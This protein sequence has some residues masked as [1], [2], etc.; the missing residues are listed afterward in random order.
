MKK[1]IKK[2][3]RESEFD[4]VDNV[5]LPYGDLFSEDDNIDLEYDEMYITM[6]LKDFIKKVNG[7]EYE[8]DRLT[9]EIFKD[10]KPDI[11]DLDGEQDYV[12]RHLYG[13]TRERLFKIL[14]K[15]GESE[16]NIDTRILED[17]FTLVHN[18]FKEHF[19]INDF[20]EFLDFKLLGNLEYVIHEYRWKE[21]RDYLENRL[22]IINDLNN[23]SLEI[24]PNVYRFHVDL[25]FPYP[26]RGLSNISDIFRKITKPLR[27]DWSQSFTDEWD[28]TGHRINELMD[29]YLNKHNL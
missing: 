15:T 14:E 27:V 21:I 3:L 1:L 6:D 16:E 24:D 11:W 20:E 13:E 5:G 28:P 23:V 17:E 8:P 18:L 4:W 25:R 10:E 19:G 22:E 7:D 9:V 29:D 12:G 2:I 26:Y